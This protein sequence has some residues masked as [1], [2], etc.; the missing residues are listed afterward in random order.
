M[1]W[2]CPVYLELDGSQE[3]MI[4]RNFY[5]GIMAKPEALVHSIC[6]HQRIWVYPSPNRHT[7]FLDSDAYLNMLKKKVAYRRAPIPL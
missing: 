7:T 1:V 4:P 5:S 2:I 6:S 3:Q